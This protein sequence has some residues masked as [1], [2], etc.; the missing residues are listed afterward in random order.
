[1]AT[2]FDCCTSMSFRNTLAAIAIGLL[3]S[4]CVQAQAIFSFS[5]LPNGGFLNVDRPPN[6]N[7]PTPTLTVTAGGRDVIL[8]TTRASDMGQPYFMGCFNWSG[9]APSFH[10]PVNPAVAPGDFKGHYQDASTTQGDLIVDFSE[11]LAGFGLSVLLEGV[12]RTQLNETV[13][14]YD[15]PLATGNVLGVATVGPPPQRIR[16]VF[17]GVVSAA[18]QIRSARV[19]IAGDGFYIDSYAVGVGAG[20]NSGC[21]AD[22]NCDAAVDFFDYLDFVDAFSSQEPRADF[23]G[24]SVIDFFDYLDFV[25]AFSTGC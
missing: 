17:L 14:V 23:N 22:F 16:V 10:D 25:D 5:D 20:C 18:A 13:T 9:T 11:P 6:C 1:M 7:F 15:G 12:F 19:S 4:S 24:D 2:G 3:T 8:T 21:A